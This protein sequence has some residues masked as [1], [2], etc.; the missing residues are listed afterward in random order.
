MYRTKTQVEPHLYVAPD[1]ILVSLYP[2]FFLDTIVSWTT[3]W[4]RSEHGRLDHEDAARSPLLGTYHHP[5]ILLAVLNE[6]LL[7]F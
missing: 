3:A 4:L 5:N 6:V 2:R 7:R 1:C